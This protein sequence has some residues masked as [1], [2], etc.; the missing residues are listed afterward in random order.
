MIS[1]VRGGSHDV[2]QARAILADQSKSPHMADSMLASKV[3]V[4]HYQQN[5]ELLRPVSLD[6]LPRDAAPKSKPKPRVQD[7][8]P[9]SS[10]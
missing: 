5:R 10:P 3:L 1:G 8:V 7:T 2:D 4:D 6:A 9:R